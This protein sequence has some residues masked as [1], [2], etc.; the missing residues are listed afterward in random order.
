MKGIEIAEK[1][2][3]EYGKPM[4]ESKFSDFKERIAAGLVGE[5]SEC[6]GYDDEISRD[7]DFDAGFCL[8]ITRNDYEKFGFKLERA[9]SK[10][11]KE[12]M[13]IK[14][15][16]LSPVG[17]NRKGVIIIEDFYQKFLGSEHAPDN[18]EKWLYTPSHSLAC[19]C[20][21]KIF[22]DDLGQFSAVRNDLLKGY[23]DD[24]KRKKLAAHTLL[25]AQA[26]QYNYERC[27][28]RGE[29]GAAQLAVFE[30]V[31]N[32]ISSVYLLNGIYE[33]FYKWA[34]KG[35][36]NLDVLSETEL[37]L[38]W[39]IE[40]ENGKNQVK[41]KL[42]IIENLSQ[43]IIDEYKKLELSSATCNNLET[44]AYSINDKISD[45]NLRTSHILSGI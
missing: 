26:G 1:F 9:Y 28:K 22:C 23:P 30:F 24:I 21:G 43:G 40:S 13:G 37:S 33:P 41:D 2:F 29:T 32:Y 39:L 14:R 5:G 17:G 8:F 31:K 18:N 11:P 44:H 27:V 3:I 12:F 38:C 4:I 20:N 25:M 19:S 36:R 45:I 15:Q 16:H 6:F 34:F 35:L 10:L 7:H 42:E